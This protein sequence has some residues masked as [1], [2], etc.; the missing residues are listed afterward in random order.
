MQQRI[1][2]LYGYKHKNLDNSLP[3]TTILIDWN[4]LEDFA[5]PDASKWITIFDKY[6]VPTYGLINP[7]ELQLDEDT[8]E[9]YNEIL[10]NMICLFLLDRVNL[11]H[12]LIL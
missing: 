6:L 9:Y 5:I 1:N 8:I 7:D 4:N 11:A 10:N 12:T 2:A 3:L